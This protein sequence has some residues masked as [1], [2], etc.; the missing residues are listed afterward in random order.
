MRRPGKSI[1]WA[2][3]TSDVGGSV[4]TRTGSYSDDF[5]GFKSKDIEAKA[6]ACDG[7]SWSAEIAV[8]PYSVLIFSQD[9]ELAPES[10]DPRA[11]E[12]LA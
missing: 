6:V 10:R 11:D 12:Q 4:S 7:M 5:G 1:A 3:R 9:Q 2:S 8:G